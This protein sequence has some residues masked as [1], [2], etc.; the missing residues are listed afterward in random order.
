MAVGVGYVVGFV[1]GVAGKGVDTYFGIMGA[2]LALAGCLLG[3]LGAACI[4][5]SQELEVPLMRVVSSLNTELLGAILTHWFGPIDLL[6]YGIA[7][8][9][10][11]KGSFRKIGSEEIEELA[12]A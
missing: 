6:F 8:W 10:G 3:N 9:V 4:Q 5:I 11:Y 2:A 12:R 1:V 7:L